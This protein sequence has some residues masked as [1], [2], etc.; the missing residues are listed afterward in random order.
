MRRAITREKELRE[1]EQ[2]LRQ[3]QGM[4][5][6]YNKKE[7][8]FRNILIRHLD[9]LK[10]TALLEKYLKEDEKKKGKRLLLKFNEVVYGQ[11][12]LDWSLLFETLNNAS[13]GFF[14]QL[15]NR[16]PQLDASEFR[17]CCLAYTDFNNTE[18]AL[19]LNYRVSSVEVKKSAIRKKLGIE[20]RGNIRNF[21]MNEA[22]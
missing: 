12:E 7:N 16:F 20:S 4:V 5:G 15:K 22:K 8:S 13:N 1:T 19:I 10:K 21:L 9:I 6:R 3:M 14:M 17:I 2:K 11:K 18:I